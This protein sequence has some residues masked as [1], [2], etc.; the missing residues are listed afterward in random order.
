MNY[1]QIIY[2]TGS[3]DWETKEVI[4]TNEQYKKVQLVL[5]NKGD[6]IILEDKP[7]IKR[8]SIVSINPADEIV[9]E[10][11]RA[12]VK[13]D[14]LL[15]PPQNPLLTGETKKRGGGLKKL[16]DWARKQ[17]WFNE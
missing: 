7:T 11:Q 10:Y 8:T 4:I 16:G 2:R 17:H 6:L 5:Q 1:W 9:A 3:E 14:G 12:G 15:D 13:V